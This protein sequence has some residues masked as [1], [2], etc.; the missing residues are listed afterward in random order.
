MTVQIGKKG[1]SKSVLE[2]IAYQLKEKKVIK[3]KMLKSITGAMEREEIRDAFE[4]I[5][6]Y[7]QSKGISAETESKRGNTIIIKLKSKV[8]K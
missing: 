2:E 6:H 1:L 8:A 5:I 7:I 3:I 4:S